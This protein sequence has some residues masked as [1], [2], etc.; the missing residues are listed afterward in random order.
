VSDES[1]VRQYRLAYCTPSGEF[2]TIIVMAKPRARGRSLVSVS[3]W[4]NCEDIVKRQ[5]GPRAGLLAIT[6]ICEDTPPTRTTG[7]DAT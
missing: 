7:G 6:S 4:K 2:S 3:D 5:K 1:L